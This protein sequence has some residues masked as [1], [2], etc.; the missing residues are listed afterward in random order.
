MNHQIATNS[1]EQSHVAEDMNT[2]VVRIND[3]A[4]RNSEETRAINADIERIDELT[5]S[6]RQLVDK[7]QH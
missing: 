4:D 1:Q 3:L 5:Q 6:V 7:F 2:N